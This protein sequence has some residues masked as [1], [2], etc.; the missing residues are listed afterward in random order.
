MK[1]MALI[2]LLMASA[3]LAAQAAYRIQLRDGKVITSDDAMLVKDGMAYFTKAG[4]YF[5]VPAEQVDQAATDRLNTE[6]S[7]PATRAPEVSAAPAA[8]PL[9][10]GEDQLDVIKKRSRL[11]NEGQLDA[12]S[13]PAA[14]SAP[15]KN[16]SQPAEPS[17]S[18]SDAQAKLADLMQQQSSLQQEQNSL[19]TQLSDL[20]DSYNQ[21]PQNDDK[22]RIQSQ[23]DSV[24]AQLGSVQNQL[25]GLQGQI[26]SAQQEMMAAPVEV[27]INR[28]GK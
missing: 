3:T 28:G 16:G 9:V 12:N 1:R 18:R 15:V 13:K 22:Q 11:A 23:I 10:I 17:A 19:S 5:Y 7:A 2:F 24:S 8:K 21:S 27:D 26:S 20:K 25:S 6:A 4:V 14:G